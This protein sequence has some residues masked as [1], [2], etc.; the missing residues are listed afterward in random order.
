M[1]RTIKKYSIRRR[2]TFRNRGGNNENICPICLEKIKDNKEKHKISSDHPIWFHYKCIKEYC[3]IQKNLDRD[4]TCP[5]C[6]TKLNRK[7]KHS[8]IN[9]STN[10]NDSINT[11]SSRSRR[12]TISSLGS[13]VDI[14]DYMV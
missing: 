1:K 7:Y 8:S 4:C 11:S 2:K 3:S 14:T 9:G 13:F 6:R 12:S 5:L 10:S